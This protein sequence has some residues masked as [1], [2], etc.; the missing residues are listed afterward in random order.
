KDKKTTFCNAASSVTMSPVAP[1]HLTTSGILS[2]HSQQQRQQQ[3]HQQQQLEQVHTRHPR[4]VL[5]GANVTATSTNSSSNNAN[6]S[7]DTDGTTDALYENENDD[8][9]TE[10]AAVKKHTRTSVVTSGREQSA[11]LLTYELTHVTGDTQ[12]L[13]NQRQLH[14]QVAAQHV[15]VAVSV[16]CHLSGNAGATSPSG[17]SSSSS[18]KTPASLSGCS[19]YQLIGG[20]PTANAVMTTSDARVSSSPVAAHRMSSSAP[21]SSHHAGTH[22]L[23]QQH[24]QQVHQQLGHQQQQQQQ[25]QQSDQHSM[26]DLATLNVGHHGQQHL[27]LAQP[28]NASAYN[29]PMCVPY[30]SLQHASNHHHH[31][32]PLHQQQQ[33]LLDGPQVN[34]HQQQHQQ[35]HVTS[36]NAVFIN[37]QRGQVETSA[38]S[39]NIGLGLGLG[40]AALMAAAT[41]ES[42]QSQPSML[43]C[44]TPQQQQQQQQLHHHPHHCPATNALQHSQQ[45]LIAIHPETTNSHFES[46]QHHHSQQQQH[47]LI[48]RHPHHQQQQQHQHLN[49]PHPHP[50]HS[51]HQ[52]Q[53]QSQHVAQ[54]FHHHHHHQQQQQQLQQQLPHLTGQSQQ[55]LS[56]DPHAIITSRSVHAPPPSDHNVV[57][58][59]PIQ[60]VPIKLRKY[61]NRPCKTPLHERHYA[62]PVEQCDRRFSR[63]D[64]L[65]RHIRIHTGQKPFRCQEC[66]RAFS[67]SDHLTTHVRTHTGEKPFT[68]EACGRQFARSDEKKRHAKVHLKQKIKRESGASTSR[69]SAGTNAAG[70]KRQQ[71]QWQQEQRSGASANHRTSANQR[72]SHLSSG[73]PTDSMCDTQQPQ[74]QN[75]TQSP[76]VV[77]TGQQA[78][79]NLISLTSTDSTSNNSGKSTN[80]NSN[81]NNNNL[82]LASSGHGD[83]MVA[84]YPVGHQPGIQ[85]QQSHAALRE[86]PHLQQQQIQQQ[87]SDSNHSLRF[88]SSQSST[89]TNQSQNQNQGQPQQQQANM[90][91]YLLP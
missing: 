91:P 28:S 34:I 27:M 33:L 68:C 18:A 5:M 7:D 26:L 45:H 9:D 44:A 73:V 39:I 12:P 11:A 80:S 20:S 58:P 30:H 77:A 10:V 89:H 66:E 2:M 55:P 85:Q 75:D 3:H 78:T 29:E 40:T 88:A 31:Q 16:S 23:H 53:H 71:Q 65:T 19:V 76:V 6:T 61:P 69:R 67:R 82:S 50:H 56:H 90:A 41:T 70:R 8:N 49:A 25:H 57:S 83:L 43:H 36:Q 79:N 38:S 81:S 54:Q 35:Q 42:P 46:L 62:C 87:H 22:H 15:H 59:V 17:A 1:T 14:A 52:Q 64:E 13:V 4:Q 84:S 24:H 48:A 47:Q 63:S 21:H 74:N 32:Q 72:Q 86:V 60:L 51:H 37:G